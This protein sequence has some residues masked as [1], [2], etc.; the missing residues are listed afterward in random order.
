MEGAVE[1]GERAARQVRKEAKSLSLLS[2]AAF[3]HLAFLDL[4]TDKPVYPLLCPL[5]PFMGLNYGQRGLA[6]VKTTKSHLVIPW[7]LSFRS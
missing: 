1:A 6:S 5:T 4:D 3:W 7:T 2:P